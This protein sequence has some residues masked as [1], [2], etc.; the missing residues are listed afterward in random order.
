MYISLTK[1]WIERHIYDIDSFD[2]CSFAAEEA[3]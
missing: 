1:L 2:H 3:V